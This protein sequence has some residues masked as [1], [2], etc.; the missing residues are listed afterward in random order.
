MA[1]SITGQTVVD[2]T[3]Y[4]TSMSAVKVTS[5]VEVSDIK[6]ARTLMRSMVAS[7][8]KQ[9]NGWIA[10][11]RLEEIAGNL[12]S[13]RTIVQQGTEHCPGNED[14]WLEAARLSVRFSVLTTPAHPVRA[15]VRA[16]G[17][18]HR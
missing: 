4:L 12:K 2:P 3:G 7:N 16:C 5:D 1:D 6:K 14:V 11:A 10:F 13:A 15:C 8:P 17:E 9:G 18:L